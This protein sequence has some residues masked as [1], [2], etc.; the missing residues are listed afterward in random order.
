MWAL[1][2]NCKE[3][4]VESWSSTVIGCPMFILNKKLQNLKARLK[5][6]NKDTFG[7]LHDN[8]KLT[9]ENLQQIQNHIMV[10]GH[11]NML[12]NQE[13]M[14]QTHMDVALHI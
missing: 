10:D 2:P 4:I 12:S 11:T 1:Y 14:A 9:G 8:V 6:W 13:K 7:N 5:A 3:V